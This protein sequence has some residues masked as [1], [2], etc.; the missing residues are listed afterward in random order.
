MTTAWILTLVVLAM[1]LGALVLYQRADTSS[2]RIVNG[3]TAMLLGVPG[4]VILFALV[5]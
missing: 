1:A 2:G 4:L 3:V 5:F